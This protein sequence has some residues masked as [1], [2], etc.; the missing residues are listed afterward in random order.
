MYMTFGRGW[1][2]ALLNENARLRKAL[3]EILDEFDILREDYDRLNDIVKVSIRE[4]E[5]E[6]NNARNNNN[7]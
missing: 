3:N 6:R 7:D 5:R 4:L 2:L 1:S